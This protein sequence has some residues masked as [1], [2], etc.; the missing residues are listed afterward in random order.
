MRTITA[1]DLLD[2]RRVRLHYGPEAV[3]VDFAPLAERGGV[4]APLAD[5][6]YF[7]QAAIGGQGRYLTWPDELDFCADALWLEAHSE[8]S[9]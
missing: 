1:F 7:A 5:R 4:Y 6:T 3:E 8:V 9:R 2:G